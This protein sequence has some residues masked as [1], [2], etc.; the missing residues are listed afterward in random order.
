[1]QQWN[2]R[3]KT[4]KHLN[5][6]WQYKKERTECTNKQTKPD[7]KVTVTEQFSISCKFFFVLCSN[8]NHRLLEKSHETIKPYGAYGK[9]LQTDHMI[10]QYYLHTS[11]VGVCL[12]PLVQSV[13]RG[14]RPA[15]HQ[16]ERWW[17][18]MMV[19]FVSSSALTPGE[20]KLTQIQKLFSLNDKT[21]RSS[22]T[23]HMWSSKRIMTL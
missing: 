13:Q 15:C 4:Q 17:W 19:K 23:V 14:R 22:H 9:G 2:R 18:W 3:Y 12:I 20:W 1:M 16:S 5:T 8:G 11:C 10:C 7:I 21:Q 6:S